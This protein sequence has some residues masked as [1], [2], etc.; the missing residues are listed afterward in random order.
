MHRRWHNKKERHQCK[1]C[2]K[3]GHRWYKCKDGDPD[4]IAAML[5]EKVP[6]KK[7]KKITEPSCESTDPAPK[8]M[9]F[10]YRSG[11]GSNQLEPLSIKYLMIPTCEITPPP[12]ISKSTREKIAKGKAKTAGKKKKK[13]VSVPP[14]SP[15]MGT[16]S[17]TPQKDSPT[18]D[19]RS[20]RKLPLPDLNC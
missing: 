6:P 20:K 8:A 4:D 16:R 13:E 19:T 12:A 2:K 11:S 5:A 1:V 15:A 9:H 3:Y 17:K 7:R 14:D 18:S 10:P